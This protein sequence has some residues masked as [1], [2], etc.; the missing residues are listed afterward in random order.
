MAMRYITDLWLFDCGEGT[1]VQLRK[2]EL[3]SSRINKIFITHLHGDHAFGLAGVLCM[4]GQ[5]V[6]SERDRL[7]A[8]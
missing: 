7:Q 6:A 3:R 2:S 1:Q 4:I 8:E 5:G